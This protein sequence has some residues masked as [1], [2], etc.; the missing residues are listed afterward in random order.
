MSSTGRN[1]GASL[2]ALAAVFLTTGCGSPAPAPSAPGIPEQACVEPRASAS[3]STATRGESLTLEGTDWEACN[4][5][6]NNGTPE[7]WSEL[8]LQW[9]QSDFTVDLGEVTPVD[10]S[11]Q[12]QITVPTEATTGSA[13][14]RITGPEF[15]T[16]IPIFVKDG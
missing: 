2:L 4:D 9:V 6:P 8:T 16:E 11:F 3:A 10:G 13:A 5:T 1:G 15:A 14:I 7:H 12:H